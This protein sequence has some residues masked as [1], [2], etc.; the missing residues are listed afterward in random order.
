MT[1]PFRVPQTPEHAAPLPDAVDLAVIGGGII[2]LSTAIFAARKGLRVVLLEKGRLG[3]EQSS[4][5]WGWIR[6]QGR[7][8]AEIPIALEAQDRWAAFDA[9]C[10]G[11][12]GL[13]QVG[14]TYIARSQAALDGYE[15]WL[16][17][18][19]PYGVSSR[20]LDREALIALMGTSDPD[21]RGALHTPTDMV[22]EPWVAVPE[23]G[24][25]AAGEGVIIREDTAVR[26][27]EM[28]AG[29]VS[30]VVTE[31]GRVAA[32]KVVLAGGAWSSLFLRRHGVAIPQ[33]SV[34]S[35]IF[36]TGPV[37]QGVGTAVADTGF[38]IRPRADGGYSVAPSGYSE[39]FLGPD[40][41]RNLKNYLRTAFWAGR[42]VR[43]RLG[44][45]NGFPD[46]WR[47][48]RRW[49]M[50]DQTPFER[51]RILDPLPDRRKLAAVKARAGGVVPELARSSDRAA[52]AG[53]IDVMPDLVPIVDH[54]PDLPG[55][56]LGTGMS[57]HGFGIGPAFG[58]ILADL[59]VG[60]DPG[61]DLHRFRFDRFRDGSPTRL[62]P[63]I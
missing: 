26:G 34:R 29:T 43:L 20:I 45:P 22:G 35:S 51:M 1:Y 44:A 37:Q 58:R 30:G 54:V 16:E 8:E 47:T 2:G 39:L 49:D 55:L 12:L 59:A 25:L 40:A 60:D 13:N 56:I 24:R 63:H 48:P 23:L 53:M 7:D 21:W 31:A 52:W 14:V 19:R 5:N 61:H 10:G 36:A 50:G 38:A 42:E 33:L 27:L 17:I 6:V 28:T 32:R 11:T 18:A 41:F 57:G 3:A 46:A 15:A 4:R 62:G 9:D